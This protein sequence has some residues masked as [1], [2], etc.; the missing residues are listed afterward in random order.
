MGRNR[1]V[2]CLVV[3]AMPSALLG[4][5]LGGSAATADPPVAQDTVVSAV[6]Q[7]NTPDVQNGAVHAI[8]QLGNTM[9]LGG[10]F[11]SVG[12]HGSVNV[13][14]RSRIVA[15]D[16]TTGKID[17]GFNPVINGEVDAV[18][19]GPGNSV[20]VAGRFTTVNGVASRVD[21]L[22]ATTGARVAGWT[23]PTLN[24]LTQTLTTLGNT[25]YVGGAFTKAG[26]VAHSG[27]VAL[28]ATTGALIPT[29]TVQLTGRHGTGSRVGPLGP[30]RLALDPSGTTM[31]AIGNFKFAANSTSA[32][33]YANEQVVRL[34]VTSTTATVDT[35]WSTQR[36]TAQCANGA[37]D[38]YIRDVQFSPDGSYFVI[39]ATG[40][41]T[42]DTNTD[43]TR[44]LCDS[45]AR[46]DTGDSGADVAP[47]WVDYTGND[48]F[49][50]VA[51]TGTAIYAGGHQRWINNTTASDSAGEG[52]VPRPGIA[53]LDPVNGLPLAWNP[54]RNPRGAGAFAVLATTTGLWVGSD[55]NFIGNSRYKHMKIAFFPLA[56]G[57]ALQPRAVG[58]LP[59]SVYEA[60]PLANQHPEVLYRVDAAGPTIAALDGGPDWV[61]DQSDPSPY[62]DSG[63]NTA[64]YS[65]L[66]HRGANLPAS[67]PS[68]IFDSERWSP[69]GTEMHWDFPVPSGN[70]VTVRLF[71]ANRYSGTSQV[72]QRVFNVS[73]EGSTVLSNYDIVADVGD[74]TGTMKEFTGIVSDGDINIATGHVHENPLINGIEIIQTDPTPP[75]PTD[76]NSLVANHVDSSGV[77]GTRI[78]ADTTAMDWTQVRGAFMIGDTLYYGKP[79]STFWKR[80]YDGD[81]FGP[82]VKIDPYNDPI[83]SSIA[84]G[85]GG[86]YRGVVSDFYGQIPSESSMFYLNGRIY[87]TLVGHSGM[88]Y[89]YFAPDAGGTDAASKYGDVV[90]SD[91]FTVN[92]GGL[93]WSNIAGAFVTGSTLYY[94]TKSDGVLHQIGWSTDHATGSSTVVDNTQNWSSHGLFLRSDPPNRP[95]VAQFTATCGSGT[96]AC[97]FDASG[98]TDQDGSIVSYGW[99]FGDGA[100]EQHADP[101]ASH[102]YLSDG[103]KT[104]TL[105]VTDDVG[106]TTVTSH[107]VHPTAPHTLI[108]FVG[109]TDQASL[110]KTL[111][112]GIPSGTAPGDTLLL[113]ESWNS[114]AV[115]SSTPAGW[116]LQQTYPNG[117]AIKTNVF[118]KVATAA[119]IGGTAVATFGTSVKF[120]ATLADYTGTASAIGVI[121]SAVDSASSTH[122]TPMVT[123]PYD[124]SYVLSYWV[125]K[126]ATAPTT[127]TT[128][129][130]LTRRAVDFTGGTAAMSSQLAD[131][132]AQISAGSYG[133]KSATVNTTSTKGL[134]ITLSL[135]PTS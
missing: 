39:V 130:E 62:R 117:T 83:W 45:A 9:F 29:M 114:P 67:T 135:S 13:V 52:A 40:G 1:G 22:D 72:G 112:L 100:T 53:A 14:S 24:G 125:D 87:Y 132:G 54:G 111:S 51:V 96:L 103:D 58:A 116:T 82:E 101:A 17:P 36:Y 90:G 60:G 81:T 50:S 98:S 77:V 120:T 32:T 127:W 25:L 4:T 69:G 92:D 55:T 2:V 28:N 59:G 37:F 30:I 80:S 123:V 71:F 41:G 102:T 115:A 84:N 134:T 94:V 19:P 68:A 42:F 63:S 74:Q 95:P 126:S 64:G 47:T 61:A 99:D 6:P 11:T 65:P 46:W 108:S 12:E 18:I 38:S 88:Y 15:F 97:S 7:T 109:E 31:V 78:T 56:G 73:L 129:A 79:D 131:S 75:P 121:S 10:T 91:Q 118:S 21:R 48:T 106:A 105:T 27:L 34:D 33:A 26:G 93:D 76:G 43:G 20:F 89:R 133:G 86:T 104:V 122:V 66:P 119:D 70:T 5:L 8:G 3:L 44:T 110:G 124:G 107:I 16:A 128:P 57:Y 85:S 113:F 35:S 49:W 23:P